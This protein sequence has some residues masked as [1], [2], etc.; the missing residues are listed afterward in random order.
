MR[1]I[2]IEKEKIKLRETEISINMKG[3]A[4]GQIIEVTGDLKSIQ[5]LR[6]VNEKE[7]GKMIIRTTVRKKARVRMIGAEDVKRGK[8]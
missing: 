2:G 1:G 6:G 4:L 3:R 8:N 5:N 7:I